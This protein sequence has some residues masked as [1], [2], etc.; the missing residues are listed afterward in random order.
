MK[1]NHQQSREIEQIVKELLARRDRLRDNSAIRKL[2]LDDALESQQF[3]IQCHELVSSNIFAG[4]HQTRF[5]LKWKTH[6]CHRES[7]LPSIA[8]VS[9]NLASS[10]KLLKS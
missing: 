9:L 8:I 7:F 6:L 10:S 3:F 1:S 5:Q 2:R 4:H